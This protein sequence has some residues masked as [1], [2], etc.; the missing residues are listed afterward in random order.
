MNPV[1]CPS[2]N[3]LADLLICVLSSSQEA[4]VVRTLH[5][6]AHGPAKHQVLEISLRLLALGLA[7]FAHCPGLQVDA[8]DLGGVDARETELEYRP[9]LC[10]DGE[11]APS[12]TFVAVPV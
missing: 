8:F 3:R 7:G 10:F 6:E 1:V 11:C 2:D 12:A 9:L 4:N 5:L